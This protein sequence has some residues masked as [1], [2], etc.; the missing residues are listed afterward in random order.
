MQETK[1][2]KKLLF[3]RSGT[4]FIFQS[5]YNPLSHKIRNY[6][7]LNICNS[8]CFSFSLRFT[9]SKLLCFHELLRSFMG[10]LPTYLPENR[11]YYALK[12]VNRRK[13]KVTTTMHV[14]NSADENVTR[15]NL[16]R[17]CFLKLIAVLRV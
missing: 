9:T 7:L 15:S 3:F 6:V 1:K 4:P 12:S 14:I 10:L 2:T 8:C 16:E 11:K 13:K 5:T 17:G